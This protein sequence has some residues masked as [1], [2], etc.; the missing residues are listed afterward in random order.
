M[1]TLILSFTSNTVYTSTLEVVLNIIFMIIALSFT[2][3]AIFFFLI[4]F[5]KFI[6]RHWVI[7]Q[8]A[9]ETYMHYSNALSCKLFFNWSFMI[10]SCILFKQLQRTQ[11]KFLKRAIQLR[12]NESKRWINNDELHELQQCWFKDDCKWYWLIMKK[13]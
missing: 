8:L 1:H 10:I 13:Q 4:F 9:F 12:Q 11:S 2:C 7:I 6:L 3:F 5:I